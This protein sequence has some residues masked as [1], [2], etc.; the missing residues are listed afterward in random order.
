MVV[1][2]MFSTI[3]HYEFVTQLAQNTCARI[4]ICNDMANDKFRG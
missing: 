3:W 1:N 2:V 4:K